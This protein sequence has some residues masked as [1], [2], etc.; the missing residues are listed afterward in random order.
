[1]LEFSKGEKMIRYYTGTVF[2]SG[3]DVFVNTVNCMGVMGAGIAL[4]F[5]LRYP[6]MFEEYVRG[7]KEGE[8]K[9]GKVC[10]WKGT[11]KNSVLN[12]PTKVDWKYGSNI[13]WIE[14]GLDYFVNN[15]QKMGITSIAFPK[16][17]T[18]KGGLDWNLVKPLMEKKLGELEKIE[19]IICMDEMR[20]A[21]GKEK[22]M[23]DEIN[24]ISERELQLIKTKKGRRILK[25]EQI[26]ILLDKR[27]FKRFWE[28]EKLPKIGA[29]TY[30]NLFKYFYKLSGE[31]SPEQ[32]VLFDNV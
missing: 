27:P 7:C 19:I 31:D 23:L 32:G 22:E 30:E 16:L 26:T 11:D 21:A 18:S 25:E 1:M 28:I 10:L 13:K 2:N 17:G 20:E 6:Q 9:P 15:Y 4:E 29:T 8:Y 3:A 12:F 5:R 24:I 14:A